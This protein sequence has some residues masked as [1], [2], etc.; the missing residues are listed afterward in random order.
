MSRRMDITL[1]ILPVPVVCLG[2]FAVLPLRLP[3][4]WEQI[5]PCE[6]FS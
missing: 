1:M 6:E 2:V 4:G 3:R 5:P